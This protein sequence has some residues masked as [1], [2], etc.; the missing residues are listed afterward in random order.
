MT[1]LRYIYLHIDLFLNINKINLSTIN[2][3]IN[4]KCV[5]SFLE[6]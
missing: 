5:L 2:I 6:K 1:N 3:F 4:I